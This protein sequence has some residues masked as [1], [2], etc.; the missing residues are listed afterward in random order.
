[1]TV[2]AVNLPY[3]DANSLVA[4]DC[5]PDDG[6]IHLLVI[7]KGATKAGL[8]QALNNV[9][10]GGHLG[11]EHVELLKVRAVRLEPAQKAAKKSNK[12]NNE[13]ETLSAGKMVVD[14]ELIE[15]GPVHVS[16]L[17]SAARIAAKRPE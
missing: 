8:L 2:Y 4:P 5:R 12:S 17:P 14:G 9:E 1:M 10:T 7:R 13:D 6:N 16:V 3:A 11:V 15:C